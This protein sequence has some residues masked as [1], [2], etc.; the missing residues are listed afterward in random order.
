MELFAFE[1]APAHPAA[2]GRVRQVIEDYVELSLSRE[3]EHQTLK[4]Y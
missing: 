3:M 2:E 1:Q 4:L